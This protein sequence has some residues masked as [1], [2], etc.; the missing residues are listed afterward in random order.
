MQG[1]VK[2]H[3]DHWL[4]P[5]LRLAFTYIHNNPRKFAMKIHSVEVR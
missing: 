1:C 4:C 5:Q 2:Q 3:G